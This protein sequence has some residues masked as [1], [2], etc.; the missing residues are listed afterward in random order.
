MRLQSLL[1][2]PP[3]KSHVQHPKYCPK[4]SSCGG[5]GTRGGE[6]AQIIKPYKVSL[7]LP[8]LFSSP[9]PMSSWGAAGMCRAFGFFSPPFASGR[10]PSELSV[11]E[12]GLF[13]A[14][15]SAGALQGGVGTWFSWGVISQVP[16]EHKGSLFGWKSPLFSHYPSL[17]TLVTFGGLDHCS[18]K[19]TVWTCL[20]NDAIHLPEFLGSSLRGKPSLW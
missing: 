11:G 15:A 13:D 17:R 7:G 3:K 9:A 10:C 16:A 12:A 4:S 19:R 8:S 2:A 6:G 18:G 20:P 5:G 14:Q 1:P